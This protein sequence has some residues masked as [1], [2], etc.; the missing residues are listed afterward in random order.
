MYMIF[1]EVFMEL[2]NVISSNIAQA[3]HDPEAN[4]LIVRFKSGAYYQ[5]DNVPEQVFKNFITA[6]SAGKYFQSYIKNTYPY[7]KLDVTE[8]R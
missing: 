2:I 5:Y 6:Q 8:N 3:G 4:R 1:K 7:K